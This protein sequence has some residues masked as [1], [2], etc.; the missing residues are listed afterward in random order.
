[1]RESRPEA[2]KYLRRRLIVLLLNRQVS[3]RTKPRHLSRAIDCVQKHFW[4]CA[5]QLR[6]GGLLWLSLGVLVQ[7]SLLGHQSTGLPYQ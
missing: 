1:M 7:G 4:P 3:G 6:I 2:K 5:C